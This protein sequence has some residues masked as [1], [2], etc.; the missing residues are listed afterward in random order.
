MIQIT[1]HTERGGCRGYDTAEER[2]QDIQALKVEGFNHFVNYR[3][4]QAPIAL[5]YGIGSVQPQQPIRRP[6]QPKPGDPGY[7][8]LH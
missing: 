8:L 5:N 1:T 7:D 2:E 6:W 4:T 3:D